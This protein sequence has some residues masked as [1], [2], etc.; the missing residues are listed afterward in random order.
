MKLVDV[1]RWG[2]L[3]R[4]TLLLPLLA[5]CVVPQTRYEEARSAISVEQEAHRSTLEQLSKVSN[6]LAK[7]EQALRTRE[8]RLEEREQ[9]IAEVSLAESVA[10]Q[11][12]ESATDLVEQLRGELSRVADHLRAFADDK[13]RLGDA[14][15]AMTER[16]ERLA[17]AEQSVAT[18]AGLVRDLSLALHQPLTLGSLELGT[19]EGRVELLIPRDELGEKPGAAANQSFVAL[20]RLASLRKELRFELVDATALSEDAAGSPEGSTPESGSAKSDAAAP[21][22]ELSARVQRELVSRGVAAER[23]SV[24]GRESARSVDGVLVRFQI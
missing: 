4:S 12:K 16:A 15:K 19:H 9:K 22:V 13:Q 23:I 17:A 11:E 8:Q 7:A 2:V 20:N 14:L 1:L 21:A 24:G 3:V 10:V 5:G 18:R 6:D